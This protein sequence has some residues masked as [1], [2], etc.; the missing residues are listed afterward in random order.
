MM[1]LAATEPA[2]PVFDT[3]G[4]MKLPVERRDLWLVLLQDTKQT[5]QFKIWVTDKACQ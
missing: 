5:G 4:W 1:P 2:G 3:W